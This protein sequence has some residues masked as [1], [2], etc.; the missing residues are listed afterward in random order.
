MSFQDLWRLKMNK[1]FD[2]FQAIGREN[3]EAVVAGASAVSKG[4]QEIASETAEFSRKSLEKSTAA[5]E[6]LASAKTFDKVLETQ[7][8]I[9]RSAFEDMISQ[10]TKIGEIYTRT[11]R[12]AFKPV[13]KQFAGFTKAAGAKS[14]AK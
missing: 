12:E 14:A 5:V 8:E 6:A 3:I 9:A 13:E 1:Q 4:F 10:M 11:A 2:Q 7:Q